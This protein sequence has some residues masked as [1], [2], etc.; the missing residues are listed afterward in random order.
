MATKQKELELMAEGLGC[1]GKAADD[2]PLF[3]LR[4]QDAL[5]ADLVRTWAAKVEAN[6][7][8]TEHLTGKVRE[9]RELADAMEAWPNKR[10]PD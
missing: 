5:A 4:G 1:L 7:T 2:E 3:I 10:L 9:A 8:M 6:C